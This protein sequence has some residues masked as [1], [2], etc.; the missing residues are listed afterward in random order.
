MPNA[1]LLLRPPNPPQGE[2]QKYSRTAALK[3]ALSDGKVVNATDSFSKTRSNAISRNDQWEAWREI[4]M[5]YDQMKYLEE[6][7]TALC[8][9]L[10]HDPDRVINAIDH[11]LGGDSEDLFD[12]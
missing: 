3:T 8:N 5:Q 1:S 10:G 7:L 9:T 6:Q 4:Q 12:T 2:S 11:S